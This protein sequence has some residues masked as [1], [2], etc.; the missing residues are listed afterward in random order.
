MRGMR[1]VALIQCICPH[2][3]VPFFSGLA[4]KVDLQV[5]FGKGEKTGAWRNAADITGFS[6]HRLRSLR[7][8]F[9]LNDFTVRLVWFPA[10]LFRLKRIRP[11][12]IISE[13]LTN[14][15]NNIGTWLFCRFASVPWI[16]W[17]SGRKK[18]KPMGILRRLVEYLNIFLLKRADAILAYGS[19]A[20][21]YFLSLGI[22]TAKIFTAYN[23]IDV[24]SFL[25]DAERRKAD[26]AAARAARGKYGISGKP[27]ILYVGALE[28][29]K[30]IQ[31]LITAY[32][33]VRKE[34]PG[35]NLV[36]VGDGPD[37][38]RLAQMVAKAH[39][40]NCRFTGRITSDVGA[41]F[42]LADIFVLPGQGG[43]AVN[44]AMSYAL[45]VVVAH[46]DGTE[47]DLVK[48]GVNGFLVKDAAALQRALRTLAA[49]NPLRK[50]M[51]EEGLGI[52]RGY[53][54][55]RMIRVFEKAITAVMGQDNVL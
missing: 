39:I 53:T 31:D 15:L 34:F 38:K 19:V 1:R 26:P 30:G 8:R 20:G 6:Y 9:R 12:V 5:F 16:I 55:A 11:D 48:N 42:S 18:G 14:I 17:D 44:Q 51:G 28:K 50:K 13:G 54:L 43:L 4:G 45:P 35:A 49:D 24:E 27:V 10:L 46:G 33:A 23:T 32:A 29:R 21:R 52:I 25:R 37:K 41:L 7:L 2:Y 47:T 22:P 36:I 3:R 40:E